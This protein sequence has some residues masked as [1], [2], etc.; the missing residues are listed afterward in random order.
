MGETPNPSEEGVTPEPRELLPLH[1]TPGLALG[2]PV[3]LT[4]PPKVG[5]PSYLFVPTVTLAHGSQIH[6]RAVAA[7]VAKVGRP[8]AERHGDAPQPKRH[9]AADHVSSES[10]SQPTVGP[11]YPQEGRIS[12][13]PSPS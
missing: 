10:I 8:P 11:T 13:S 9:G 2:G 3:P 5:N 12:Q 6:D 1:L 4:P 7:Q